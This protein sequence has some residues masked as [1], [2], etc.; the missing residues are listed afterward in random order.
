MVRVTPGA[1]W[2]DDPT[3][4]YGVTHDLDD[5]EHFTV[6]ALSAVARPFSATEVPCGSGGADDPVPADVIA[7]ISDVPGWA[8]LR[9]ECWSGEQDTLLDLTLSAA[10][11]WSASADP[12]THEVDRSA[13]VTS[14]HALTRV[15]VDVDDSYLLQVH[16]RKVVA[17]LPP[18]V[19]PPDALAKVHRGTGARLS[20]TREQARGMRKFVIGPGQ[21]VHVP[22]GWP[23]ATRVLDEYSVSVSLAFQTDRTI[24]LRA[25]ALSDTL[26]AH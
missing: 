10:R 19:L 21:G 14:A 6:A 25:A 5:G 8:V 9:D 4:P 1:S 15:H 22:Y 23:H 2:R 17:F 26:D 18:S 12:G 24:R 11:S 20:V 16:G 7:T 3:G 13:I